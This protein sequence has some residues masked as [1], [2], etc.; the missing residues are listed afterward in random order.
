MGFLSG[1]E[2]VFSQARVGCI[3][4]ADP[5]Q[6]SFEG[7]EGD[8]V[9]AEQVCEADTSFFWLSC[10]IGAIWIR[11]RRWYQVCSVNEPLVKMSAACSLVLTKR[12]L[13]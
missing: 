4:V 8:L 5:E 6:M 11:S 12:I 1:V 9:E 10:F 2:G 13:I 7:S 3:L